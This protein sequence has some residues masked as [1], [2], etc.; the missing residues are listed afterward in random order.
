MSSSLGGEKWN[1][2]GTVDGDSEDQRKL[3]KVAPPSKLCFDQQLSKK[4]LVAKP[5]DVP[6]RSFMRPPGRQRAQKRPTYG[7]SLELLLKGTAGIRQGS[8]QVGQSV[9]S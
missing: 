7:S 4:A 1:L 8:P 9:G 5:S 6:G 2:F 3:F